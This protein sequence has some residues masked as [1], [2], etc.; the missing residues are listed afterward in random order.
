ME[1]I[2]YTNSKREGSNY[3]VDRMYSLRDAECSA[4]GWKWV[5]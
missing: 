5:N 2:M 3:E 1:T 4:K